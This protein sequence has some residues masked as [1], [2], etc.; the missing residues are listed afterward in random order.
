MHGESSSPRADNR[1]AVSPAIATQADHSSSGPLPYAGFWKRTVAYVIDYFLVMFLIGAS[2]AVVA[3]ASHGKP[4]PLTPLFAWLA[5]GL[6]Y[7]FF[8]SSS[9]QATLGK[10]A[11]DLKVTDLHGERIGFGRALGRMLGH[12]LSFMTLSVGFAM[13]VFTDR[14]QTLHDKMAGTLV[15]S[16]VES[17][18]DIDRAGIAPP[19]PM[20][21]SIAAVLG[22]ML[23]GPMGIGILA[24]IAIPAYQNFT[25]RAQVAEGLMIAETYKTAIATAIAAGTPLNRIDSAKLDVSLP[26]TAKYVDSVK[27][28]QGAIDIHY[29]RAANNK[30]QGGHLILMPGVKGTEVRWFCGHATSSPDVI[31]PI[32][33]Y[34]KYTN[35]PDSLLPSACRP[36]GGGLDQHHQ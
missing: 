31:V 22:L 14:R 18:E 30:I 29:G 10:R 3:G 19:A 4:S 26:D 32:Q 5:V 21:Q 2:M 33:D 24:A 7:V 36:G 25:L 12:F 35:I 20:W 13:A 17:P 16:R 9:M 27:V 34:E 28:I 15:V 23:F 6:Y 8:E 1:Y 11:M